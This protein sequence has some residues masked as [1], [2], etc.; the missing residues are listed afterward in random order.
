MENNLYTFQREYATKK[1]LEYMNSKSY[2]MNDAITRIQLFWEKID[3][4][5]TYE[6]EC[7]KAA[8]KAGRSYFS[9][10]SKHP[11]YDYAGRMTGISGDYVYSLICFA[12]GIYNT[13]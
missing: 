1:Y 6:D 11:D 2:D 10:N 12:T 7:Y 9:S 4:Y 3:Y 13:K 8:K 5:P